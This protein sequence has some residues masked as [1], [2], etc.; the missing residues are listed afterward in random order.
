M[1]RWT[2]SGNGSVSWHLDTNFFTS[3]DNGCTCNNG[4]NYA[5]F[6]SIWLRL[7]P[8]EAIDATDAE[9]LSFS[10]RAITETSSPSSYDR[11]RVVLTNNNFSSYQT[12]GY[13]N[14]TGGS[15]TTRNYTIPTAY[16][17]PNLQIGFWF[18]TLDSILNGYYGHTIDDIAVMPGAS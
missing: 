17:G 8:S 13:F 9:S 4:S 10:H 2:Q 1:D 18:E 7:D 6:W 14:S 11:C 12:L 5:G 15:W 16:R 3:P